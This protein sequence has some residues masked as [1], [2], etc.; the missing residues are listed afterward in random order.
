LY[1]ISQARGAL[2][3]ASDRRGHEIDTTVRTEKVL[4][5]LLARRAARRLGMACAGTAKVAVATARVRT[6]ASLFHIR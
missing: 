1:V 6:A 2:D 3:C 5:L 4:L